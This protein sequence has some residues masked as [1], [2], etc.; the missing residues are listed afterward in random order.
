[1]NLT[2]HLLLSVPTICAQEKTPR[3]GNVNVNIR[4]TD[5][6]YLSG[7][8]HM[9]LTQTRA[10]KT[11]A[12]NTSCELLV[13]QNRVSWLWQQPRRFFKQHSAQFYWPKSKV[14]L[15]NLTMHWGKQKTKKQTNKKPTRWKIKHDKF[16]L[17]TYNIEKCSLKIV[18][19]N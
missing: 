19:S 6:I 15:H 9:K 18:H 8:N 1:M 2:Q 4:G 3:A 17:K 10:Y 13:W 5:Y 12:A 11:H 14:A 16:W 7:K